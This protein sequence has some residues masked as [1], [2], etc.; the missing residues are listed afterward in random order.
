MTFFIT[1]NE[2]RVKIDVTSAQ[3]R[4]RALM[5]EIFPPIFFMFL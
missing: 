4:S 1:K 5:I 3:E 2:E